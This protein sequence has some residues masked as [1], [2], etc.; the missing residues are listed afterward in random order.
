LNIV[1]LGSAGCRIA[2]CFAKY[3]QYNIYKIDVGISGSGCYNFPKCQNAEEY[4][5]VDLPKM[6]SFFKDISGE[7]LAIIG[8]SGKISCASLRVL[9]YIK[10]FPI[11]ILYI[12][13]DMSLIGGTALLQHR[14]VF[15][16]LQEYA[17]SDVFKQ[18][19]LI[20]N[21]ALDNIIGGAPIIGYHDKLN[22]VLVPTFHMI[23]VF[24]NTDSVVGKIDAP[25]QTHKIVTIGLYDTKKNEE[26]M[27]FPLDKPRERCYIYGINEEKLKSDRTLLKKIIKQVKENSKDDLRTSYAVFSTDYNYD[28]RYIIERTPYVQ[29]SEIK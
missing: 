18:I 10:K 15:G 1:G 19:Y 29:E 23:K 13:P 7:T 20:S 8:G 11:S 21:E 22:E 2:D 25:K 28:V 9:E 6:K 3:P 12:K 24:E 16:I 27:F 5:K 17:R 14:V 26:K 4:E